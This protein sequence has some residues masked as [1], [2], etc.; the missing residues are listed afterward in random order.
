MLHACLRV[1]VPFLE[2]QLAPR[3]SPGEC[4][5]AL[6]AA[7]R[8]GNPPTLSTHRLRRWHYPG[9]TNPQCSSPL[10]PWHLLCSASVT[11]Q[12]A[13]SPFSHKKIYIL[14]LPRERAT[15]YTPLPTR[16]PYA[17]TLIRLYALH[18]L[19]PSTSGGRH[20]PPET[21]ANSRASYATIKY[22]FLQHKHLAI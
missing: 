5:N 3:Y 19:V 21:R 8:G 6:A 20:T 16:T 1:P 7:L 13:P 22:S 18:I 10:G 15:E 14:Y 12:R 9:D 2:F 11:D 4:L 17:L